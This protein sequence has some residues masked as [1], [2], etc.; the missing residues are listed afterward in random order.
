MHGNFT[1]RRGGS[2]TFLN[3]DAA[4][5]KEIKKAAESD[6]PEEATDMIDSLILMDLF[7]KPEDFASKKDDISTL[8]GTRLIVKS[9]TPSK[10]IVD[11]GEITSDPKFKPFERHGSAKRGNMAVMNL[12][13]RVKYEGAPKAA[14]RKNG[15]KSAPKTAEGG[16]SDDELHQIKCK[17]IKDKFAAIESDKKSADGNRYCP[18]LNA[19]T[20]LLRVFC[21]PNEATFYEE[22]RRAKCLL[23]MCP[24]IDFFL[25]YC[26]PLVFARDRILAAYKKGVDQDNN[27]DCYR[28]FCNSYDSPAYKSDPAL[29]LNAD[30]A[31]AVNEARDA[32]RV[33]F[34]ER[35][36]AAT[37]TRIAKLYSDVDSTNALGD[38]SPVYCAGL[39]GV[40]KANA[41]LHLM[42]D[43]FCHLAYCGLQD[44]KMAPTPQD[45]CK[46]LKELFHQIHDCYGDFSRPSG[47]T[48]LDVPASYGGN[49]DNNAL[50][51]IV[52]DFWKSWGLHTPCG[53][54]Q[55]FE[56]RVA[57]G[58]DDDD[59][60]YS[61]GLLDVD[62]HIMDDLDKYDNCPMCVSDSAIAEVKQWMKSHGGKLPSEL[63]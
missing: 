5:I 21:D 9:V 29:L 4:Y 26:N 31:Q 45:K 20:R 35:L 15:K 10:V 52:V 34:L 14:P 28:D 50:Y 49:F 32:I 2:I 1:P 40:F 38:Q 59:G 30:G 27:V 24:A 57:V 58:G 42:L 33:E 36:S 25:L 47:K 6:K 17:I 44:V 60:P 53:L 37:P 13:G 54:N 19:V 7:E 22:C 46:R 18:L 8:L 48:R 63:Q 62:K 61:K 23:T 43:E 3:P 51:Q 41:G 55:E 56:D 12:K 39:A 16:G 11:D